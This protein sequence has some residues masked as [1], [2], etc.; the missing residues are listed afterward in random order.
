[1][2]GRWGGG[3]GEAINL[4]RIGA[5]MGHDWTAGGCAPILKR[6]IA[7]SKFEPGARRSLVLCFLFVLLLG[8]RWGGIGG[9]RA[10]Y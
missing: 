4:F 7:V 1:M 3:V 10:S 8:V 5:R 2:C 9:A 6:V